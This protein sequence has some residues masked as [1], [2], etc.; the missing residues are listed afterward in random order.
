MAQVL[1]WIHT[2]GDHWDTQTECS[3]L[4]VGW[5]RILLSGEHPRRCN[6]WGLEGAEGKDEE[7]WNSLEDS[8]CCETVTGL[9]PRV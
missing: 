6:I 9:G 7:M 2:L 1:S 5:E 3:L 8:E 4:P